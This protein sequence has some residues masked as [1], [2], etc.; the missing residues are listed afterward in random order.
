MPKKVAQPQ[1]K[2]VLRLPDGLRDR[3]KTY[4]EKHGRS[5]NAEI[6]RVLQ[7]EYPAPFPLATR[8]TALLTLSQKIK[9]AVDADVVDVLG[10][11]LHDILKGIA[12]GTVGGVDDGTRDEIAEWL[13]EWEQDVST[14]LDDG[15]AES[16]DEEE[17]ASYR[18]TGTTAK[19]VQDP[20]FPDS[21]E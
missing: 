18:R 5:M 3:I 20:E 19:I 13:A 6:V 15:Y 16:F 4:A 11:S 9:E 17:I 12:S 8:V 1:D 10:A 14:S 2:Y 21:D 7:R